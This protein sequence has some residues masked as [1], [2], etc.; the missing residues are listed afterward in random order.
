MTTPIVSSPRTAGS[1]TRSNNAP[2]NRALNRITPSCSTSSIMRWV[3]SLVT[4]S[5]SGGA[6]RT[7]VAPARP[8]A[9]T[10]AASIR[11]VFTADTLQANPANV[12]WFERNPG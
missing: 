7:G 12:N 11:V 1:R 2:P 4:D 9:T 6:P 10:S 8:P 3:M 5:G